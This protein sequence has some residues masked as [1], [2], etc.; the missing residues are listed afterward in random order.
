[1][2]QKDVWDNWTAP[3]T[4]E[5]CVKLFFQLVDKVEVSDNDVEFKPNRMEI[6]SCR[7][8]DTHQLNRIIPK[9]KELSGVPDKS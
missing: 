4:L 6:H 2:S 8:W 5:E 1:M 3:D 9:M 7:V